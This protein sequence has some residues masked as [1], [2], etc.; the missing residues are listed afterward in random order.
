MMI[1]R[2]GLSAFFIQ[3][4]FQSWLY[5]VKRYSDVFITFPSIIAKNRTNSL[6]VKR[7]FQNLPFVSGFFRRGFPI[8]MYH[9]SA[10]VFA[11]IG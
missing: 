1:P 2:K 7:W 11:P 10:N 9:Q 6:K 3:E 8:P 4:R 5:N